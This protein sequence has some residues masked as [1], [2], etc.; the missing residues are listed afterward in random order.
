MLPIAKTFQHCTLNDYYPS[1]QKCFWRPGHKT[2]GK[3]LSLDTLTASMRC[4]VGLDLQ[5]YL[6][7][8]KYHEI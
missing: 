4:T 2:L 7:V 8:Q 3:Q 1:F 5:L 6:R